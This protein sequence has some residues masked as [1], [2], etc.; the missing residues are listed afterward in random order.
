MLCAFVKARRKR[1]QHEEI[2]GR[3]KTSKTRTVHF[4]FSLRIFVSAHVVI[5]QITAPSMFANLCWVLLSL[6]VGSLIPKFYFQLTKKK[7]LREVQEKVGYGTAWQMAR[8]LSSAQCSM[9]SYSIL[10]QLVT[11]RYRTLL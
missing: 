3:M 2:I 5:T 1:L 4:T 7:G 8:Q 9:L 6:L 11:A 10:F